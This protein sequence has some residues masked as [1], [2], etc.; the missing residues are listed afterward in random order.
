MQ[1][2]IEKDTSEMIDPELW[3]II[4]ILWARIRLDS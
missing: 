1:V 2:E 4:K 3:A